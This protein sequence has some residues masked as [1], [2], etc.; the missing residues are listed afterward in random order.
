MHWLTLFHNLLHFYHDCF[1]W[2]TGVVIGNLLA[3][4]LWVPVQ[5]IGIRI[6]LAAH[7]AEVHDRLDAQDEYMRVRLDA[8][9]AVMDEIRSLL[10]RSQPDLLPPDASP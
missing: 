8:Q 5:W 9:D 3:S 10:R 4:L 7:H 1:D 6:R 2:P